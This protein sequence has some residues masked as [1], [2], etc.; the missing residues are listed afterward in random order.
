MAT[1]YFPNKSTEKELNRRLLHFDHL[2]TIDKVYQSMRD[3]QT[4]DRMK[5]PSFSSDPG[6]ADRFEETY[7]TSL[8]IRLQKP[9]M[10][11]LFEKIDNAYQA[12]KQL[13]NHYHPEANVDIYFD[14]AHITVKSF[15]RD[16]E[17]SWEE[18]RQIYGLIHPVV[19]T[20]LEKMKAETRL[21]ARGLFSHLH[22]EKGL[23][24]GIRFFPSTTLVQQIRGECGFTVYKEQDK[25]VFREDLLNPETHFHTLLTHSTGLRARGFQFPFDVRFVEE[26]TRLMLQYDRELFGVVSDLS[27]EDFFLGNCKTDRYIITEKIGKEIP[28]GALPVN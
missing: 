24:M 16:Q 23:S 18:M 7:F 26:F 22:P 25:K 15:S 19:Q 28:L 14:T 21:F 4:I 11:P 10:N 9:E 3:E 5:D 6:A 1:F 8:V 13:I 20:W 2:K 12:F 17:L 27:M